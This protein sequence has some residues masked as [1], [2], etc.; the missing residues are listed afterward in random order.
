MS[1]QANALSLQCCGD[2]IITV[3]D[4]TRLEAL[5]GISGLGD[6]DSKST[7][8]AHKDFMSSYQKIFLR[9][10]K[11]TPRIPHPSNCKPY[12]P[13]PVGG[14]RGGPGAPWDT[15][16]SQGHGGIA[17]TL[18]A[19][20]KLP[21]D[22]SQA[23][24]Q[25]VRRTL[26]SSP[27][28]ST[29]LTNQEL[30]QVSCI[31]ILES[32]EREQTISR[33]DAPAD[34]WMEGKLAHPPPAGGA[35]ISAD[36]LAPAVVCLPASSPSVC[37][38]FR[39][40][41]IK[42]I[43]LVLR[44]SVRLL[45]QEASSTATATIGVGGCFGSLEE[46][47]GQR[48]TQCAVTLDNCDILRIPRAAYAKLREEI[49][50]QNSALR[51]SIVQSCP[52]YLNWPKL[53]IKKL[54]DLIQMRQL[55]ANHALVREGEV[56]PYVAYIRTGECH[57]LRDIGGRGKTGRGKK[58]DRFVVVGT[59]RPGES[60]GEASVLLDLP[61]PFSVVTAMEVKM[62][63]ILPGD[64]KGLDLVT[65]SLIEQTEEPAYG[66]LSQEQIN[67]MYVAQE[68]HKEWLHIKKRVVSDALLYNGITQG[69]GKWS[70]SRAGRAQH[71][72]IKTRASSL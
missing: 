34:V 36:R 7:A 32:W 23:D 14:A 46:Q 13:V 63:V 58:G 50:A 47:E 64:L 72:H 15:R 18:R 38:S 51:E 70:Q 31:A 53:S 48:V 4:Y 10:Q 26:S 6:G 22:R 49:E 30:Q 44:G 21:I 20:R 8:E 43:H 9:P 17:Q 67:K 5:C 55:P 25:A 59:L 2:Q 40:L 66:K 52:F 71:T 33:P 1:L 69:R 57:I 3:I 19:L 54:S 60:F 39:S 35:A 28:I 62:A 29:L 61:S 12:V 65:Q 41:G 11:V 42:R 37:V 56:C 27:C 16:Q 24:Q 45:P 68:R